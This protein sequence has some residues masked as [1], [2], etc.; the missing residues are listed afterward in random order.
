MSAVA[1]ACLPVVVVVVEGVV[2]LP[3]RVV[4]PAAASGFHV[5]AA[6]GRYLCPHTHTSI[7]GIHQGAIT[8]SCSRSFAQTLN[9]NA[10]VKILF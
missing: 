2:V 5:P 7:Y 8:A 1:V 3:V 9:S 6:A 10:K 4:P